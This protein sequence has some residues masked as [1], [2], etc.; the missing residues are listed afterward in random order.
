VSSYK[1]AST[2]WFAKVKKLE[3]SRQNYDKEERIVMARSQ[4][5]KLLNSNNY[6]VVDVDCNFSR[7]EIVDM[8]NYISLKEYGIKYS[9]RDPFNGKPQWLYWATKQKQLLSGKG[10][11]YNTSKSVLVDSSA[12]YPLNLTMNRMSDLCN[13]S[14]QKSIFLLCSTLL[15][16]KMESTF[17]NVDI[18]MQVAMMLTT[19]V[20]SGL[21]LYGNKTNKVHNDLWVHYQPNKGPYI[22]HLPNSPYS[23]FVTFKNVITGKL[24]R[25][26]VKL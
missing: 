22:S 1:K 12:M 5:S 26:T 10:K 6:I 13:N 18:R 4:I 15:A 23:I 19:F 16:T 11:M 20:P 24:S 14:T 7:N 9:V 17:P 8:I 21:S 25:L 3:L 2:Y